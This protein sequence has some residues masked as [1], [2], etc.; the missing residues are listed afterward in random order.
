MFFAKGKRGKVY[1]LFFLAI[2]VKRKDSEALGNIEREGEWLKLLNEHEIGPKI[3]FYGKNFLVYKFVIGETI[4][5]YFKHASKKEK[6]RVVE[7]VFMQCRV[8]DKLK[9][10][11][12][13]MNHQFKHILIGKKVV[14]ID[15]E[16]C[17]YS[18]KP[19][20]VTQFAQSLDKLSIET[21]KSKMKKALKRYKESY[22]EGD[23]E[24][25]L[26]LIISLLTFFIISFLNL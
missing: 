23:Y 7:E 14:M 8:L 1:K 13:E 16:R 6:L 10:N 5:E 2:K 26:G 11:K 4:L 25:I 24:K 18:E 20:N 17:S 21:N 12:F 9:I 3:Y 19:K 15:F 22:S